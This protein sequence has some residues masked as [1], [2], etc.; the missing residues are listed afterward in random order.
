[1]TGLLGMSST[2]PRRRVVKTAQSS[3]APPE[4]LPL[5]I[6]ALPSPST[7]PGTSFRKGA[8]F[9]SPTSPPFEPSDPILHIPSLP[10]RSRTC[11]KAL[12]AI[13]A[14]GE[15]RMAAFL[16]SLDRSLS[17]AGPIS[18]GTQES[19]RQE[20]L[21]LP[22]GMLDATVPVTP[23]PDQQDDR[24]TRGP[25]PPNP[26]CRHQT[27]HHPSDSGIGSTLSGSIHTSSDSNMSS[28]THGAVTRSLS[29]MSSAPHGQQ[30]T[31]SVQA[32]KEIVRHIIN[33]ILNQ[34]TLKD[35]HPLIRDIPR[36]INE[37]EILCL[38]DL[39]TT[40]KFL[41]DVREYASVSRD[42][43]VLTIRLELQGPAKSAKSYQDFCETS[44]QCIITT[45]DH[46]SER[47]QCR[48]TDAPYSRGY[49]VNLV[50]QVR[51]RASEMAASEGVVLVGGLSQTGRPARLALVKD[52]KTI[53]I[54]QGD[55]SDSI[56]GENISPLMKR[57]LSDQSKEDSVRRSMARRR[58]LAPGEV[59]SDPAPQ[60]C[61]DCG[62]DF[63]RPCDLT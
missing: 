41:A 51:Q 46:I 10:K 62:K 34:A 27:K 37:K 13:V 20:D 19:F 9:H 59:V 60:V 56:K 52:G 57:S 38:R 43:N 32:A 1:M 44:I 36:R 49:F 58:K 22:R 31:L 6:R 33:P 55:Q 15:R 30:H 5:P 4:A 25:N 48:P 8:T 54:E 16:G 39:E 3:G 7:L 50:D 26:P 23:L 40:L 14:A 2:R 29:L 47:D 63:K 28:R 45:V 18:P 21:P 24:D 12:D 61:R 17:D 42:M 53:P 11:P 35:F